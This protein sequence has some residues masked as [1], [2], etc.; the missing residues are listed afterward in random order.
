MLN[1]L[2]IRDLA[3]VEDVE[4]ELGEGLSV[5]TGETGAG[6]SILLD[7]VA[8]LAGV[9]AS[10]DDIRGGAEEAV[11]EG[12][13]TAPQ[14][15]GGEHL[16]RRT[17][18]SSGSRAWLDDKLV[19]VGALRAAAENLV[20]IAG[21]HESHSLLS[22]GSHLALLDRFGAL[23]E[24]VETVAAA[25]DAAIEIQSLL[26]TLRA[27]ERELSQRAD[28]LR[29]QVKEI[30][31]ARLDVDEEVELASERQ[32]LRNAEQLREAAAA[33]LEALYESEDSAVAQLD[34]AG[35]AV[36]TLRRFDDRAGVDPARLDEA[37]FTV[38]DLARGLQDYLDGLESDPRRLETVESRLA[39]ID[40]LQRKYGDTVA[41][42]LERAEAA[43]AELDSL[44]NRDEEIERATADLARRV[45]EYDRIA[46]T[47][48]E[49][50]R[51]AA[52]RLEETISAELQQL[53]MEGARFRVRVTAASDEGPEGLPP[54]AGR[55]GYERVEFE[56]AA[57]PGEPSRPL[58]RVASGGELS[59]V[60]LALKLAEVGAAVPRTLVFDEID[61]G[62]GG[63][64]VADRLAA[65]LAE[66]G[67]THQVLVVTHLPQIAARASSHFRV[68]KAESAGRT[69]VSVEKL[70]AEVRVEELA[71]M[72]GGVDPTEELRR[73][74]RHLLT[75]GR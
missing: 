22:P 24:E 7:G 55:R 11:V 16:I 46:S 19:T 74:A 56:L 73:H 65:R 12:V 58:A 36:A 5:L 63:G 13:L 8:L 38:D 43:R 27:D 48:G 9:R 33:A 41:E 25:W 20:E 15:D 47:L 64:R 42:I 30:D 23:A 37:R 21:Q 53:G 59:R 49:A 66:L 51:E 26:Q 69:V 50:R 61:A 31:A 17:V 62:V 68:R 72:L 6:K 2:R 35:R 14:A 32:R 4:L 67:G 57:N 10:T 18:K 71:R 28:F 54:G 45:A 3:L 40:T 44:E 34:R 52:Q 60:L 39:V 1:Y 70:D 75:A 29:F